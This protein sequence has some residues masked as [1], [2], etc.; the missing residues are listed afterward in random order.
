M[1]AK[2]ELAGQTVAV[3]VGSPMPE[4]A[5]RAYFVARNAA[6]FQTVLALS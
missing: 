6:I 3:I 1:S 5:R 2:P 4:T